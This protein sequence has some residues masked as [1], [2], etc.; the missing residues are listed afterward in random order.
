MS[1]AARPLAEVR[2]LTD[3]ATIFVLTKDKK[4]I[5][6]TLKS[7]LKWTEMIK[8]AIT[9]YIEVSKEKKSIATD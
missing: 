8:D 5:V 3:G 6:D 1:E 7:G 4:E 2:F 9:G